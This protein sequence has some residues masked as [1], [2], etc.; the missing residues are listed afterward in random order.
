MAYRN[1][2]G[3]SDPTAGQALANIAREERA[4]RRGVYVER[5]TAPARKNPYPTQRHKA[6][7]TKEVTK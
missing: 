4:K 6:D 7:V 1:H 2:E 5:Y 3:Y